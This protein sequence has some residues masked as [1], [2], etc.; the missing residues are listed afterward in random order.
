MKRIL[1]I[2]GFLFALLW[3]GYKVIDASQ[4]LKYEASNAP[5]MVQAIAP[6]SCSRYGSSVIVAYQQKEYKIAIPTFACR[7]GTYKIGDKLQATYNTAL[8]KMNYQPMTN[9]R[10]YISFLV[11]VL[12]LFVIYLFCTRTR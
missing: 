9:F 3:G 6:P 4:K 8:D 7:N 12:L 2:Y 5:V 10:L 1:I 11:F